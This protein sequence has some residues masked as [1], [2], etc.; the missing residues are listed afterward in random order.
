[1]EFFDRFFYPVAVGAAAFAFAFS[2]CH[3]ARR[4]APGIG[5]IDYP[6]EARRVHSR[7]TPRAGGIALYLTFLIG[8]ALFSDV[9]PMLAAA[10]AGGCLLF[11]TGLIDDTLTLGVGMRFAAQTVAALI[12][13]IGGGLSDLGNPLSFFLA[14]MFLI[15]LTNAHNFIDGIDGLCANLITVEAF[16]I[17]L[18]LFLAGDVSDAYAMLILGCAALGFLPL[19]HAPAKLFLGDC[20]STCA[21]FL[22]GCFSLRWFGLVRMG[23]TAPLSVSWMLLCLLLL[24]SVPLA[25]LFLAVVRRVTRVENPFLPDR[26]HLHH[27]L[28][29]AGY[30]HGD[31][32]AVLMTL[33]AL[34][35]LIGVCL[36]VEELWFFAS[37][38]CVA[39]A[40]LLIWVYRR[41]VVRR[42]AKRIRERMM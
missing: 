13:V 31:A 8:T 15:A 20:G 4:I 18:L 9:T 1:M 14:V 40:L 37:G 12:A 6:G 41:M 11:L 33:A 5:A 34:S 38:G 27:L 30:S 26:G 36:S 22:A 2:L 35:A 21:G 29:D 23:G 39:A 16:A 32:G 24:F 17:G 25:D 28:V 10:W 42:T 19:G 7:P 3:L